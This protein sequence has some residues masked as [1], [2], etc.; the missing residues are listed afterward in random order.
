MNCGTWLCG[1]IFLKKKKNNKFSEFFKGNEAYSANKTSNIIEGKKKKRL[2][3]TRKWDLLN[4]NIKVETTRERI[5][6]NYAV[7]FSAYGERERV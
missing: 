4:E 7:I 3:F 5:K 1:R 6:S 2:C